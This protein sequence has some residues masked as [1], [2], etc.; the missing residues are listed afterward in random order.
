MNGLEKEFF[1][2][3]ACPDCKGDVKLNKGKTAL[4]C[5]KC[6]SKFPVKQGIPVMLPTE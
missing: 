1:N 2:I 3:L 6:K 5:S 4:I